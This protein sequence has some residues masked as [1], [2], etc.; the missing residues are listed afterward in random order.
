MDTAEAMD[1]NRFHTAYVA[2]AEW[3]SH[4]DDENPLDGLGL[5]WAPASVEGALA[6]CLGFWETNR[7]DIEDRPDQAGHDFWLTRNGHGAGF[8]DGDWPHEVGKRLTTDAHAYGEVWLYV[9]DDNL[10]H[11]HE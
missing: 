6:D 8:W 4:D 3:A 9:G 7:A 2:C 1:F 10:I 5:E 11:G